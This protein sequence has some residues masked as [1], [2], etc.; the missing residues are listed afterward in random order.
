MA[1]SR[2]I[3]KFEGRRV[4]YE[5]AYEKLVK[6]KDGSKVLVRPLTLCDYRKLR[7]FFESCSKETLLRRYLTYSD[8]HMKQD[9]QRLLKAACGTEIVLTAEHKTSSVSDLIAVS[10]LV[11]VEEHTEI[12]ECAIIVLDE[13]QGKGLGKAMLKWL[14]EIAMLNGISCIKGDCLLGNRQVITMLRNS[15]FRYKTS[16]NHDILSFRLFLDENLAET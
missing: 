14:L 3:Q 11:R 9:I 8:S 16:Y 12:A 6:L 2:T 13:W 1:Q 7:T 5:K 10:E 4:L 15:G